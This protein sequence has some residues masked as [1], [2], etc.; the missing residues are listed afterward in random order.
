MTQQITTR[1]EKVN[2]L[3]DSIKVS[4]EQ[5]AQEIDE[6]KASEHFQDYLDTMSKFHKYSPFNQFLIHSQCPAASKV[7]GYRAW[8]KMD[9]QVQKGQKSIKILAPKTF[10]RKVEKTIKKDD[11]TTEIVE[12]KVGGMYFIT[13]SVFD[14]SQTKGKDL[15]IIEWIAEGDEGQEVYESLLT[16]AKELNLEVEYFDGDKKGSQGFSSKG[17][18]GL[19]NGKTNLGYAS[20]LTHEIAHDIL[21]QVKEN[22][23][24]KDKKDLAKKTTEMVE[25]EAEATAYVVLKHFGIALETAP[26]YLA[27]WKAN[28]SRL[29][30][31]LSDISRASK[32]IIEAITRIAS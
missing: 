29:K 27:C 16:Y 5:L 4:I 25:L 14:V 20:T 30:E 11:G 15:P 2:Q 28:Q 8:Q 18:I 12:E 13:V 24:D 17:K 7:A 26:N 31:C 10:T 6:V 3:T 21:H 9:R 23:S 32:Q 19:L 22:M 1:Q